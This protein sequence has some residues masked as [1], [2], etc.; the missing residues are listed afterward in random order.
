MTDMRFFEKIGHLPVFPILFGG[1]IMKRTILF[2]IAFCL[3]LAQLSAA[4]TA[5]PNFSGKW[6]AHTMRFEN[7]DRIPP[8][9]CQAIEVD[10]KETRLK[11]GPRNYTTDGKESHNTVEGVEIKSRA[12]W[13]GAR[14]IIESKSTFGGGT[15]ETKETWELSEDRAELTI[16]KEFL[17][18]RPSSMKLIYKKQ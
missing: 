18:G 1:I 5:K 8:R 14:L 15:Q 7:A 2:P 11:V 9:D 13:S 6:S 12:S 3:C 4:Q 16:T 17:R 10:H